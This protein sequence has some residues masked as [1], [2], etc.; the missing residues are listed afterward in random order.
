MSLPGYG[1]GMP[2]DKELIDRAYAAWL[3][4]RDGRT[5]Y[6]TLSASTVEEIGGLT[7]VI[8]RR[9]GQVVDIYRY[10][11]AT[12]N[13]RDTLKRMRYWPSPYPRNGGRRAAV[14]V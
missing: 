6:P 7:Y 3:S 13:W 14:A 4:Y 8:L 12:D 1:V 10:K 11:P 2:S 5:D 9:G